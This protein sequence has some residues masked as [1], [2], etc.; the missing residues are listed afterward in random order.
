MAPANY[1]AHKYVSLR[2]KSPFFC[3]KAE[4][5]PVTGR[6]HGR[7]GL[8]LRVKIPP[9]KNSLEIIPL[10]KGER[11]AEG[12]I[13]SAGSLCD[14]CVPQSLICCAC[15]QKSRFKTSYLVETRRFM[16]I[17]HKKAIA[18]MYN[19][20]KIV[21]EARSVR[22]R[23]PDQ[24]SESGIRS[25]NPNQEFESGIRIRSPVQDLRDA[26]PFWRLCFLTIT[27]FNKEEDY[28]EK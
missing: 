2:R 12:Q 8:F 18:L 15:D 28:D 1:F 24:E 21:Q 3:T 14:T 11:A 9:W 5:V 19:Q 27:L 6:H 7:N 22:I 20:E 4:N 23:N 10:E 13:K 26:S 25:R 16:A 17:R